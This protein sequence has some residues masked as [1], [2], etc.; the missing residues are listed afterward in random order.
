[1][2]RVTALIG[3]DPHV[4]T[5][6]LKTQMKILSTLAM[7]AALCAGAV[8]QEPILITE[9]PSPDALGYV[10][11]YGHAVAGLGDD[12][13]SGTA[14][15][16]IGQ[17]KPFNQAVFVRDGRTGA[18]LAEIT[19]PKPTSIGN[20]GYAVDAIP[21]VSGDGRDDILIGAYS[22]FTSGAGASGRV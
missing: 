19:S 3:R 20:F 8:A 11:D 22:E 12:Q 15:L 5:L 4:A 9:T 16:L 14:D 6:T 13:N 2:V 17:Y 7:T 21:D 18:V 1:V 10:G